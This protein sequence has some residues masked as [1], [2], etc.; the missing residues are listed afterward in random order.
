MAISLLADGDPDASVLLLAHG[1]GAPMD[2]PFMNAIA[3]LLAGQGIQV[4][5]FEFGYMAQRR[6]TGKKAP[7]PRAEKLLG[8]FE[9]ALAQVGS[10]NIYIGGKSLGGRVA[11]MIAEAAFSQGRIKGL[12][13]LGY[14]FHPPGKPESLRTAHLLDLNCPALIVQGENDPFGNRA[15]VSTYQLSRSLRFYWAPAGN[16]DLVPPKSTGRTKEQNWQDAAV[17]VARFMQANDRSS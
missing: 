15:E 2:S 1:A 3:A 11:S 16:H 8:E 13:C 10:G 9:S 4:K 17:A 5:R 14:P 12:V 7:P 6:T